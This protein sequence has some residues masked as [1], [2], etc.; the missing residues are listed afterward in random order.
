MLA[1]NELVGFLSH[2]HPLVRDHALRC[3]SLAGEHCGTTAEPVLAV[4]EKLQSQAF[5][6]PELVAHLPQTAS[7]IGRAMH[8][9]AFPGRPAWVAAWVL[10]AP[11][12]LLAANPAWTKDCG[13]ADVRARMEA[14]LQWQSLRPDELWSRLEATSSGSEE[15]HDLLRVLAQHD[16]FA[17]PRI[18][19]ILRQSESSMTVRAIELA[20]LAHTGSAVPSL[21][22]RLGSTDRAV[23][24]A[25]VE[26]LARIGT[27]GVVTTIEPRSDRGSVQFRLAAADCLARFRVPSAEGALVRLLLEE[28][29][30]GVR[31]RLCWALADI[32]T[33]AGFDRLHAVV[34]DGAY[35]PHSDE[36]RGSVASL[37]RMLRRTIPQAD[38]WEGQ[39]HRSVLS[40]A[41]PRLP[42]TEASAPG[43]VPTATSLQFPADADDSVSQSAHAAAPTTSP[44]RRSEAKVGRNDPCPCGSGKKY[45]KCCGA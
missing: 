31:G 29:D 33:S 17:V 10:S 32:C 18:M 26:A 41:M 11:Q 42:G 36:L 22:D 12:S 5:A 4:I 24:A 14:R 37:A 27:A 15:M 9:L 25:S 40:I 16:E 1:A 20:G 45:K 38:Q 23:V 34:R 3:L 7:S 43:N 44:I 13:D 30:P 6:H 19:A 28:D 39:V 21:I 8:W 35:A 2:E